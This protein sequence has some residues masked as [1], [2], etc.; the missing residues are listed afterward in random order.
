MKGFWL[1]SASAL[2]MLSGCGHS[3]PPARIF[4]EPV[5]GLAVTEVSSSNLLA[6]QGA[7]QTTTAGAYEFLVSC[8]NDAGATAK[9]TIPV[10][11]DDHW[12]V[13]FIP[14]GVRALKNEQIPE[15]LRAIA[16]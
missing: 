10:R 5:G 4:I 13:E 9:V 2:C 3:E 6:Q 15:H 11:S 16:N 12:R 7:W 8:E 14:C 1:L